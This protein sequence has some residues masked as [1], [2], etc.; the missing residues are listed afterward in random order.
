[1]L[2]PYTSSDT[3]MHSQ[4]SLSGLALRAHV[5]ARKYELYFSR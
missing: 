5:N 4:T 3:H 1:M 2:V